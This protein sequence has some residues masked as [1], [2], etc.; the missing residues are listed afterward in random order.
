MF[1]AHFCVCLK[2]TVSTFI[3]SVSAHGMIYAYKMQQI[4][5]HSLLLSQEGATP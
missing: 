3:S 5:G 2:L 1:T 4:L